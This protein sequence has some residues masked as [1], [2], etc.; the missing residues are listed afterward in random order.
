MFFTTGMIEA[1]GQNRRSFVKRA[2]VEFTIGQW[3][4]VN[5]DATPHDAVAKA[6]DAYNNQPSAERKVSENDVVGVAFD[7][8]DKSTTYHS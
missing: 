1:L 3:V 4:E 8:N 6:T 7:Q 5:D 2:Y